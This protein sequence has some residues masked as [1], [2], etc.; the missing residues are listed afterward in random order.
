MKNYKKIQSEMTQN[1]LQNR[2]NFQ[3]QLL[4]ILNDK[5]TD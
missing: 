4:R 1:K 5:N 3:N 2:N